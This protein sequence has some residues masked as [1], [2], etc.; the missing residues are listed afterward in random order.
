MLPTKPHSSGPMQFSPHLFLISSS[1]P[2]LS[3]SPLPHLLGGEVVEELVDDEEQAVAVE[4]LAVE[5][6]G[7]G[8]RR[9][10]ASREGR[11]QGGISRAKRT[12]RGGHQGNKLC[13]PYREGRF[14]KQE[15]LNR[16]RKGN[17]CPVW[18]GMI[19]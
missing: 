18:E 5:E 7:G 14:T 13:N 4:G 6:V 19:G 17:P 2:P 3:P 11:A 15:V 12:G 10:G 8:L 16:T 9:G 1:V